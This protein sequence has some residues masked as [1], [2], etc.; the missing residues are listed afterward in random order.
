MPAS[1]DNIIVFTDGASKGNPGPG[2][3]GVVTAT[4][5][6]HVTE[7]GGGAALT[8]NNKME[9]TG[10]I[11]AFAHLRGTSGKVEVYTDSTYVIQGIREWIHGWRRRGWKTSTGSDVLNRDLWEELAELTSARGPRAITW[12]YVRGHVGTPGNERVDEIADAFATG[13]AVSLYDGPLVGYEVPLVDKGGP[14]RHRIRRQKPADIRSRQSAQDE[15][16]ADREEA[17]F[18]EID[19]DREALAVA[20]KGNRAQLDLGIEVLPRRLAGRT[21]AGTQLGD[22]SGLR[23]RATLP[24]SGCTPHAPEREEALGVLR[25]RLEARS[26]GGAP[27]GDGF[28]AAL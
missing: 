14:A 21:K 6:G 28:D 24:S 5:D 19:L 22:A 8:T 15:L 18:R 10:A 3:W 27:A 9:L 7:L 12:H 2:G 23:C 25:E 20:A 1:F 26:R 16:T 13:K 11:R 17:G 4:P